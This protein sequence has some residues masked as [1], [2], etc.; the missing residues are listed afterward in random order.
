MIMSDRN[1]YTLLV[2]IQNDR[3]TLE[4]NSISH[5]VKHMTL[6]L[7]S[8]A[9]YV[10]TQE[11]LKSLS[12]KDFCKNIHIRIIHKAKYW[13]QTKCYSTVEK[14]DSVYLGWINTISKIKM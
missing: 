14:I 9:L 11:K 12:T 7:S 1:S 8:A 4:N 13:R 5:N 10:F 3:T 2:K 6:L